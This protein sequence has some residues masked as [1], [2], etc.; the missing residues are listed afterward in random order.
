MSQLKSGFTCD[1]RLYCYSEDGEFFHGD[2]TSR[3]A[4]AAAGF[5]CY[6]DAETIYVG[7]R[8]RNSAHLFVD[9][10]SILTQVSEC[11]GD[12]AG[13]CAEDWLWG[14]DI[15]KPEK[16]AELEQLVG[17]WIQAND[18]PDFYMVK[19]VEPVARE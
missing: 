10:E 14:S 11:A 13:E 9:G 8:V 12:N 17:D 4:A 19:Y 18:P 5:D 2:H 3:E 6:P 15:R 1:D 7:L 16:V